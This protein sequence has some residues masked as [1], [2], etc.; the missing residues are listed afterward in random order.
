M[1]NKYCKTRSCNALE[2]VVFLFRFPYIYSRANVLKCSLAAQS[3]K[4]KESVHYEEK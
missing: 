2:V 3:V 1:Y 4:R